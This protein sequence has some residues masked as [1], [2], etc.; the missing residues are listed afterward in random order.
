MSIC[1][2]AIS[3]AAEPIAPT[4]VLL[5]L[6]LLCH[7]APLLHPPH[8]YAIPLVQLQYRPKEGLLRGQHR[9]R[10][11]AMRVPLVRPK[12]GIRPCE[13]AHRQA[14]QLRYCC[15]W[16]SWFVWDP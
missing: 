12:L 7:L 13:Q 4:R 15:Q 11:C 3:V 14:V 9:E 16:D 1:L 10:A 8:L 5:P 2:H 6:T